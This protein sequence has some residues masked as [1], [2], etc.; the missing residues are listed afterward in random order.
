VSGLSD[1]T[2]EAGVGVS[3]RS[4]GTANNL[5]RIV[6]NTT[7]VYVAKVVSGSY[8]LITTRV[9]A[10]SANDILRV[11]VQGTTLR[12]YRNGVQLGADIT[13]SGRATGSAGIMYSSGAIGTIDNFEGGDFAGATASEAF[14]TRDRRTPRRRM[15]QRI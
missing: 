1:S 2:A 5:Y 4:D 6:V 14:L 12:V 10:F 15:I 9:Q 13:D 8:T 11:E 7:T 3:L